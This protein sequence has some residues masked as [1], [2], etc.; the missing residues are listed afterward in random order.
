MKIW[1]AVAL[2]GAIGA[3]LRF[4]VSRGAAGLFGTGFPWGTLIVNAVGAFAIGFL[5]AW[6]ASR[7]AVGPALRALI[8]TGLLGALTTFSTFSFETLGLVQTA[9]FGKVAANIVV[10]LG[11]SL[12][13]VWVGYE[14]GGRL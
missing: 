9:A 13:L 10:N 11:M 5:A 1:L 2:G 12:A 7:F 14:L 3:T 4:A 8:L 6:F